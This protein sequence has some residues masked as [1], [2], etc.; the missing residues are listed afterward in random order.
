MHKIHDFIVNHMIEEELIFV[1]HN[2]KFEYQ[3]LSLAAIYSCIFCGE[4]MFC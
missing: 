1:F 2:C 4:C 3:N